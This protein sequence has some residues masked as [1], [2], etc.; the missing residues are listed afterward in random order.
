MQIKRIIYE[1]FNSL[2]LFSA[3]A[4]KKQLDLEGTDDP[5]Q[6]LYAY[7]EAELDGANAAAQFPAVH[8]AIASSDDSHQQYVDL[9]EI[10]LRE[11]EGT[12]LMP[13]RIPEFDFSYLQ[14]VVKTVHR[15]PWHWDAMGRLVIEFSESL[16]DS[17]ASIPLRPAH[18][19]SF[20]REETL[21]SYLVD[22]QKEADL[23]VSFVVC[24]NRSNVGTA[25]VSFTVDI[26]SLD[27]APFMADSRIELSYCEADPIAQ[28]T[29][30]FG[31]TTFRDIPKEVL[32]R[33]KFVIQPVNL[34][35]SSDPNF[36]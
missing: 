24:G 11:R 36:V 31:K 27:G 35:S 15:R 5:M 29:D 9:K 33:L 22:Q 17:I 16:F 10:L 1:I 8:G 25:D 4:S 23:R 3:N 12:L 13:P 2:E 6:L 14:S 26:P 28:T 18:L 7:I 32:S 30:P 21:L 34:K 20:G 19:K